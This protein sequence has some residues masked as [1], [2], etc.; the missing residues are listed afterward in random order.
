MQNHAFMPPKS[1]YDHLTLQ[2]RATK[3]VAKTIGL[4]V[5]A[6]RESWKEVEARFAQVQETKMHIDLF[7]DRYVPLGWANYDRMSTSVLA[8]LASCTVDEG[9]RLLAEFHLGTQSMEQLGYQF[10]RAQ[11]EPWRELYERARERVGAADFLSAVPLL[12]I[13][14]DGVCT[15]STGKH[16]FSGG[17]DAPVFDTQTS[18]PGGLGE[19]MKVLGATRRK[20]SQDAIDSPFRH[21]IVHGLNPNFGHPIVAA[22][23]L[24]LLQATIDYFRSIKDEAQRIAKAEEEQRPATWREVADSIRRNSQVRAA[25][26][27]W[28]ARAPQHGQIATSASSE[29]PDESLP[30]GAAARYLQ[31]LS[32]ANY[33]AVAQKTVDYTLRPVAFRAGRL[34]DELKGLRVLQWAIV[35]VDDEAASMTSIG[36]HLTVQVNAVTQDIETQLRMMYADD[37]FDPM[38]RGTAGGEWYAMANLTTDLWTARLRMGAQ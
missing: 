20:L 14:I 13:V 36:V 9:E 35:G 23:A 4:F 22:K 12:L 26:D 18:G 2:L 6:V 38:V 16:P 30:E 32:K 37:Q 15:T 10:H 19:A 25:L 8:Q 7:V 28:Q 24:N 34:R 29:L 11:F 27:A 33:G 1:T 21:G 31:M 3:W 5:P 17:A